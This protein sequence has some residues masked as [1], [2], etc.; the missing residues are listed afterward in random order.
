MK[1]KIDVVIDGQVISLSSE[2]SAEHMQK[3]SLYV[4][5]KIGELKAKNLSAVVDERVR[6]VLVA[7][8][9]ADDYF[10]MKDRH[11]A[12]DVDNQNLMKNVSRL[13]QENA[14]LTEQLQK[15][16]AELTKVST[17]FE[18]F[19]HSFDNRIFDSEDIAENDQIIPLPK[20]AREA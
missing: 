19:L 17:E 9:V 12:L 11:T 8:N 2:E 7:L 4:D 14:T 20:K 5:R 18:D 10:K 16:Q 15:L 3:V 6:T 1:N 13:E